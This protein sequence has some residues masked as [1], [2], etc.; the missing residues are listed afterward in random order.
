MGTQQVRNAVTGLYKHGK[1][2]SVYKHTFSLF[3]NC[4]QQHFVVRLFLR[5]KRGLRIEI[6]SLDVIFLHSFGVLLTGQADL[7]IPAVS[8][9]QGKPDTCARKQ[10]PRA[11][12]CATKMFHVHQRAP[13]K[14]STGVDAR[15]GAP[16]MACMNLIL[17]RKYQD[18][19]I[20]KQ[21]VFMTWL[22]PL[23]NE[24]AEQPA[25]HTA[26]V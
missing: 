1:R 4:S 12:M 26:T 3:F 24:Q 15:L 19:H 17:R 25:N 7:I 8:T 5:L 18:I 10:L 20:S 13:E 11:P 21:Y 14:S 2:F 9:F 22:H 23:K 16:L 6:F